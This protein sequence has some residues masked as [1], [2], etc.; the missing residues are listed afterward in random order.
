MVEEL[1][2][3]GGLGSALS[4]RDA[5]ALIPVLEHLR[6]CLDDPRHAAQAVALTHRVLDL[7]A[8]TPALAGA[9]PQAAALLERVQRELKA[10]A[11]LAAVQGMLSPLLL[12]GLS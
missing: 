12:A 9:L 5:P 7:Y 10:Q 4:S 2:G 8:G 6:R 3:R 11:A 1:A